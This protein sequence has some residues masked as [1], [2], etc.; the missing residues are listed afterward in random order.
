MEPANASWNAIMQQAGADVQSLC[1]SDTL[2]TLTHI[3]KLN[4]RTCVA[5][6][7]A[8]TQQLG[9]IYLDLI[10]VYKF[11]SQCVSEAVASGSRHAANMLV[12]RLQR[13][14]KSVALRLLAT[15][16]EKATDRALLRTQFLPPL[17][18]AVLADFG[19]ASPASRDCNVLMLMRTIVNKVRPTTT[20]RAR[21]WCSLQRVLGSWKTR[22]RA[23]WR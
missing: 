6:G 3:I 15:Y 7:G 2:Q 5:L 22:R 4:E 16:V 17:F 21:V 12:V 18:D 20:T 10:N 9:R 19:A 8:F 11:C 23:T 1:Q 14:V 13:G